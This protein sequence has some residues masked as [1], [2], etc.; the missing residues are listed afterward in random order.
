MVAVY[1]VC[2]KYGIYVVTVFVLPLFAL[3]PVACRVLFNILMK[4]KLHEILNCINNDWIDMF[5]YLSKVQNYGLTEDDKICWSVI[6][7]GIFL[8][9]LSQC[10]KKLKNIFRIYN[11]FI[12]FI[13]K[14]FVLTCLNIT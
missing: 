1:T 7:C 3:N 8:Y 6:I 12:Y 9:L 10:T 11:A 14:L 13:A 4:F 2:N 5:V